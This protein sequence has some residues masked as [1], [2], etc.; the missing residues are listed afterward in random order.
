MNLGRWVAVALTAAGLVTLTACSR[1][2]TRLTQGDGFVCPESLATP[3]EREAAALAYV[4]RTQEKHPDWTVEDFTRHRMTALKAHGCEATLRNIRINSVATEAAPPR[5]RCL[6]AKGEA[7]FAEERG[8]GCTPIEVAPGWT[9]VSGDPSVLLYVDQAS[10]EVGKEW[11]SLR[12][13]YVL[14]APIEAEDWAYD[15]MTATARLYCGKRETELMEATY[16]KDGV[17]VH[18][19]LEG[20]GGVETVEPGSYSETLYRLMCDDRASN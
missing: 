10:P 15:E 8:P 19:Q 14:A 7:A 17:E 3:E 18:R 6:D 20:E 1:K 12:V 9:E 13:R 5:Y 16:A 2:D 4:R 11:V